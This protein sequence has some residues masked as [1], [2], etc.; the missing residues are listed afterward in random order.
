MRE[1]QQ[2][3]GDRNLVKDI[4]TAVQISAIVSKVFRLGKF[5]SSKTSNAYPKKVGFSN[6]SAAE[7]IIRNIN[8][9]KSNPKFSSLSIS[10]DKTPMLIE[11]PNRAKQSFRIVLRLD[12]QT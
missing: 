10:C 11:L 7:D 5:D 9:F 12:N 1:S 2:I 3:D 4:C 6:E 8:K